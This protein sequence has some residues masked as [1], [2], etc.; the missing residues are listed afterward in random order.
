M[1]TI[2]WLATLSAATAC[3]IVI[4]ARILRKV[5]SRGDAADPLVARIGEVRD[6]LLDGFSSLKADMAERLEKAKGDLRQETADRLNT[7]FVQIADTVKEDLSAGRR[8]QAERLDV[9]NS[10]LQMK[11]DALRTA[12]EERFNGF[13]EK[14]AEA[15]R[16]VRTEMTN[17]LALTTKSLEEKFD[18]LGAKTTQ[19]LEA[20]RGKVDERLQLISQEV[21]KR[22]DQNLKD[23]F[24]QFQKVQEHLKNAEERLKEVGAVGASI[25]DL[26]NLL[27]L[28]H[29]RGK[30]GE[31]SLERLLADFLPKNM[32]DFQTGVGEDG[33]QRADA[34]IHFPDRNLPIDSK[35]PREQVLALFESSDP[36]RL[37]EARKQLERVIKEQARDIAKYIKPE[38]GTTD[39]ALMFLPSE[40]LWFEV[41]QNGA[42]WDELSRMR[43]F[44]V[45]PNTLLLALHT[46]SLVCK[47]YQ[48]ATTVQET[49]GELAKAKRHF[50]FF[51]QQFDGIG[52]AIGKAQESYQK[53]SGHLTRYQNQV[54]RLTGEEVPELEAPPD[55][56]RSNDEA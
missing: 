31:A 5:A 3:L 34:V 51:Q 20:I 56:P 40:T 39:M 46:I 33:R 35:F 52:K 13:T 19:G 53:A 44:P 43:I 42:L 50:D 45:S 10:Q 24:S 49:L 14:Q 12:T 22:L 28:P 26:N 47:S 29:L 16:N 41:V 55:T 11:F 1:T 54:V 2:I 4:A 18:G 32:Y 8:E 21:Q 48:A 15:Q 17:A 30:F 27:K 37:A 23:G 7:G 9:T 38:E 6:A 36:A 25:N